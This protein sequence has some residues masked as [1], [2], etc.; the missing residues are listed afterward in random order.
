[1]AAEDTNNLHILVTKT[2]LR[3]FS[4]H[5]T[6]VK[7]LSASHN[8]FPHSRTLQFFRDIITFES[9]VCRCGQAGIKTEQQEYRPISNGRHI[10][11]CNVSYLQLDL[12][13][14]QEISSADIHS[15]FQCLRTL[16]ELQVRC[17]DEDIQVASVVASWTSIVPSMKTIRFESKGISVSVT[18]NIQKVHR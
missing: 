13:E 9:I 15:A 16:T 18:H 14:M 17:W 1:M 12:Q 5:R 8:Q 11:F 4:S 6:K 3:W 10:S 7:P 2:D